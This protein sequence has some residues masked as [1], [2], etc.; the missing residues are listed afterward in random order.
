LLDIEVADDGEGLTPEQLASLFQP[1]NRL[2]HERGEVEGTGLGLVISRRLA[3][4][5]NGVLTAASRPGQGSVF[6]LTLPAAPDQDG[7]THETLMASG[8]EEPR[9]RT[10]HVLYIEDNE[11][12]VVVMQGILSRRPQVQLAVQTTAI[13]G[14]N[15]IEADPPDLVLLDMH[16][17]DLDGLEVLRRL[18]SQ[19][20]TRQTPVLVVSADATAE[21]VEQAFALGA[22]DYITKPVDVS[23]FLAHIDTYLGGV[24]TRY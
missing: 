12:N 13:A 4:A 15:A 18:R 16:L 11:T 17:P 19:D 5:M 9:Y 14:L 24:D 20:A 21:R 3:E 2:G 23:S 6:T 22:T 7:V 1:F 8:L 10:R